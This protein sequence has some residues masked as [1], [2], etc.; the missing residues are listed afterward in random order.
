MNAVYLT[1]AVR[2]PIGR[3][4][5][6]L[7]GWTAADMGLAVAKESLRRAKLRADQVEDSI[8]GCAREDGGGPKVERRISSRGGNYAH[9]TA[10]SDIQSFRSASTKINRIN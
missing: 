7:A 10:F 5:G 4:G 1:G 2:T 8:W 3:F 6:S 9:D